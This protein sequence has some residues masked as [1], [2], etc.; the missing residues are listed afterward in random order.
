[1][2]EKT[3][4]QI[5]NYG[6]NEVQEN[7]N[8]TIN[9]CCKS[10]EKP[11]VTWISIPDTKESK[12][13]EKLESDFNVHKLVIEDIVHGNQRPKMEE[14]K[15]HIYIIFQNCEYDSAKKQ[16]IKKQINLIRGSRFLITLQDSE[17]GLFEPIKTR[18]RENQG[19][20]RQSTVQY[21]TYC[22]IDAIVDNYSKV[23]E[24]MEDEAD[25]LRKQIFKRAKPENLDA[26]QKLQDDL[27]SLQQLVK[28][29]RKIIPDLEHLEARVPFGSVGIYLRDVNDHIEQILENIET[30]LNSLSGMN[31]LYLSM[32]SHK[33]NET[34]KVLTI[35][36]TIFIPL[37]FITGVYGMNFK[38]MPELSEPLGY[39]LIMLLMLGV[40]LLLIAFFKKRHLW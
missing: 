31:D 13:L 27:H 30:T 24:K 32:M 20:I 34:M 33:T 40:A 5:I 37:T 15:D 16:L 11:N 39:P 10:K 21:L 18:I 19:K 3:N 2:S 12:T 14:F 36:A 23:H 28:P 29:L 8:A 17:N 22:L 6:I 7:D 26:M 25:N 4:I 1:M 9:D 38:I 35:I